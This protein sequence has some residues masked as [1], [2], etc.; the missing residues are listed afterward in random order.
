MRPSIVLAKAAV[1]AEIERI[2]AR[3]GDSDPRGGSGLAG[4]P[5]LAAEWGPREADAK[6]AQ[7]LE[8][9]T[10]GSTWTGIFWEEVCEVMASGFSPSFS[11]RLEL[12]RLAGEILRGDQHRTDRP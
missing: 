5:A 6:A 3:F 4:T 9:S 10:T 11:V 12:V 2:A 7:E 8:R 1:S